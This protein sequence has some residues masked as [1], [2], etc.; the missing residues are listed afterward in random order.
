M[1]RI[2]KIIKINSAFDVP[3]W[4]FGSDVYARNA[5][6]NCGC[7]LPYTC[8]NSECGAILRAVKNGGWVCDECGLTA[9]QSA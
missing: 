6:Q 7:M 8:S 2:K 1:P 3:E 4:M 5:L 9:D